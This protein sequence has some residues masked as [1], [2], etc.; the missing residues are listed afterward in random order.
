M[1]ACILPG[2]CISAPTTSSKY[3]ATL[4]TRGMSRD[5]TI[6]IRMLISSITATSQS[7]QVN[8]L[9]KVST[10]WLSP[11]QQ[12]SFDTT[13]PYT[14]CC[15]ILFLT[16]P[17]HETKES[18]QINLEAWVTWVTRPC[19][20]PSQGATETASHVSQ[21][22]VTQTQPARARGTCSDWISVLVSQARKWP[23]WWLFPPWY[24]GV[25]IQRRMDMVKWHRLITAWYVCISGWALA[26]QYPR[27]PGASI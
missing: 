20:A 21:T 16:G 27:T 2:A 23:Q 10:V 18:M 19:W 3:W 24:D 5:V 9:N 15:A 6:E 17:S 8:L 25:L 13:T 1:L 12:S 7:A 14:L 11:S 22:A 26:M 4:R